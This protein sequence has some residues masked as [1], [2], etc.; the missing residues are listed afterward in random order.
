MI[1]NTE[2]LL[3]AYPVG[4]LY[5]TTNNINPG[6]IF[7]GT[8]E[9]ITSDA[10]LKIVNS[11]PGQL[12]GTS[13]EHKIPISSMPKHRHGIGY[14]DGSSLVDACYNYNGIVGGGGVAIVNP[15]ASYSKITGNYIN[16]TGGDQPYYPYYYGIY[17]WRRTA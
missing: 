15:A 8:W 9:K 16:Q 13:S 12:G 7:G 2:L 11:N 17:V 3:A 14:Q 6:T 10:Y 5:L 4:S 1:I